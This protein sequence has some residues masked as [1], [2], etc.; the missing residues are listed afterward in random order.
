MR[1]LIRLLFLLLFVETVMT[2]Q[3]IDVRPDNIEVLSQSTILLDREGLPFSRIKEGSFTPA[4]D[5]YINLAFDAKTTVWVK[6][7]LE[8][9]SSERL[10]RYLEVNNPLLESVVLYVDG[11]IEQNDMLHISERRHLVKPAFKLEIAPHTQKLL[12]LKVRNTTTSLQFSVMLKS[13][14]VLYQDDQSYQY[15]ISA[16]LGVIIAFLIYAVLLFFYTRDQS[17]LLYAFYLSTLLFQQMTYLGFTP[18]HAPAWFTAIDNK[19]AVFKVGI[20]I[21][22]A[23]CFAQSFLKTSDYPRIDRIYNWIII[24][25]LIQIP[26]FGT[27]WFYYPEV[28]IITGLF[29]VLFN[30][31]VGA[32]IYINGNKQARFFVI[33]WGVLVIAYLLYIF[34][35]LGLISVMHVFPNM[36][37]WAT[38]FEAL[39]LLLAIIDR[40]SLLQQEKELLSNE[41][42]ESYAL[43]QE[44]IEATVQAKTAELTRAL[45]QKELLFK[46]LHHRVKNN[47]QLILSLIRLQGDKQECGENNTVLEEL[48]RRILAIA[49]T[50]E[51]LLYTEDDVEIVDMEMY[52]SSYIDEIE[53]GVLG[54]NVEIISDIDARLPLR[55]AIYV[56]LVI[57][58]L[59]SNAIKYAFGSEGGVIEI[60]LKKDDGRF[61]FEVSDNGKGYNRE[62]ISTISLG[63]TL[64]NTL[65]EEQL[66]GTIEYKK[67]KGTHYIMR[68]G[69]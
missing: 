7:V 26:L 65:I 27:P 64:V 24:F 12:F 37:M 63:L 43:R 52:V 48:E 15:S 10:E 18:L 45:A 8:N 53:N 34:D 51:L 54:E 41:L 36:L 42:L 4:K 31:Y 9:P 14:D 11:R 21:I 2:A 35:V 44:A 13:F 66:E 49:R 1:Y 33:G 39:F 57:N 22:S 60:S 61:I 32:Y 56:G 23:I 17:Y 19:I 5:N 40:L 20:M 50:H 67:Q 69:I 46:E 3:A 28:P 47:L 62:E 38:A 6:M 59:V 30:T 25:V 16:F 55:E 58:E 29:F 68:F